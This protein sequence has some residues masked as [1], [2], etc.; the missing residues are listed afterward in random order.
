MGE[1]HFFETKETNLPQNF[2]EPKISRRYLFGMIRAIFFLTYQFDIL[3]RISY[4]D[5]NDFSEILAN[6]EI[7]PTLVLKQLRSLYL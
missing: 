2:Q 4:P 6:R 1:F 7:N 3:V 5:E